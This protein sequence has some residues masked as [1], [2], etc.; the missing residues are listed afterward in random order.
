MKMPR[1]VEILTKKTAIY[2]VDVFGKGW[3]ASAGEDFGSKSDGNEAFS[4]RQYLPGG[5]VGFAKSACQQINIPLSLKL[6]T[7]WINN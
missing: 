2:R 4:C 5:C 1:E 3:K 7:I 6:L